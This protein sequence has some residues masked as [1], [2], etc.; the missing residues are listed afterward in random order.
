ME[1]LQQLHTMKQVN[2]MLR[3]Q[4]TEHICANR[5]YVQEI[6]LISHKIRRLITK[7]ISEERYMI[8]Q[9]IESSPTASQHYPRTYRCK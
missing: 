2:N 9:I 7:P 8:D 3:R 4:T 6:F 1:R 5:S